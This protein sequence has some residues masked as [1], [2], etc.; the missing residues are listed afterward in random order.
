M[1]R[2]TQASRTAGE[3]AGVHADDGPTA[4]DDLQL[5]PVRHAGAGDS[6]EYVLPAIR[7]VQAGQTFFVTMVPLRVIAK[8]FVFDGEELPPELR[9]QRSLNK[10]R[11]PELVRYVVDNPGSYTFSALTASIDGEV[12]FEPTASSADLPSALV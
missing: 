10:G 8:L 4:S 12:H 1:A 7:G 9:A 3:T 2:A 11:L 6:Y 5:D